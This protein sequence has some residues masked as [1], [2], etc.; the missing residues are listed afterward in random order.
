MS[1]FKP[2][3]TLDQVRKN[4]TL[5]PLEGATLR[6]FWVETNDARDHLKHF[7]EDLREILDGDEV[8]RVLVH[9]HQGCGKSTEI[10]K[11]ISELGP[12]W[13]VVSLNVV[14]AL[15]VS[16]NEAADVLLAACMRI[17]EVAKDHDLKL[18]EDT[19]K[20]IVA[21][22]AKTT[23]TST[24]SHAAGLDIEA[25]ADASQT[26][27][28]KLFGLKAKLVSDL[29]FG[30]RSEESTIHQVRQNKGQLRDY[31]N[32]L[33]IAAELAWQEIA[34]ERGRLLLVIENLDKVSL[35][36]ADR[37]F[38]KDGPLLSSISLRAIYTI[39]VFTYY[40]N[41]ASVID[42]CFPQ[43][44][45]VPM[46]K[47]SERNGTVSAEGCAV[48]KQIIRH[49]V[50]PSILPDDAVDALIGATGGV[51][52]DIFQTITLAST[53]TTVRASKVID[54][55][56]IESALVRMVSELGLRICY[57][58]DHAAPRDPRP[59][60]ELLA[61][62][63]SEQRSNLA[64]PVRSNEDIQILLKSG[65][66]LEYNNGK[67]WLGVHPLALKYLDELRIHV[68]SVA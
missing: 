1:T 59:L 41:E 65:A 42:A 58:R 48:L 31:V 54:R 2:A 45:S 39:P 47:V 34:T 38:V 30:S 26:F 24:E 68:E 51:L 67:R 6:D 25:G 13:L 29:K 9:G 37:I 27:F 7:R 64:S 35:A 46:I 22:F 11:V 10:N 4:C 63:A 57:P 43:R 40:S 60:L 12:Q 49:R 36:D 5:Q 15:P 19:L 56:A 3:T 28:G 55:S 18:N 32:A 52:R 61:T 53:F 8:Q 16:G 17:V 21:F 62:I 44:L 14:D 23:K 50:A 33:G 66:L 20:P